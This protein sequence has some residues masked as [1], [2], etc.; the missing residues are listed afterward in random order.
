MEKQIV[1]KDIRIDA[2]TQQRPID[3]DVVSR[4]MALM[5]EGAKFPPVSIVFDGKNNWLW[6]GFHRYHVYAKLK[7]NTIIASIEKGTKRD[8]IFFSF[9]A[10]KDHGFP[11][12]Q[13][14]VKKMLL[15]K[16][17]PDEEWGAQT[18]EAIAKWVGVT[19][20]WVSMI[21]KE[22]EKPAISEKEDAR[23]SKRQVTYHSR[24]KETQRTGD[25][26]KADFQPSGD[27]GQ[28]N[29]PKILDSVGEIVPDHLV[30]IFTRVNE[31]KVLVHQL[32]RM[33]KTV[34]D[35]QA[36]ND[37]LYAYVKLNPLE[38]ETGNVKRNLRFGIPYAVC[39]H[40]R[41]E[42]KGCRVC[43]E[44]GFVSEQRYRATIEELK[45]KK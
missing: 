37:P 31:I 43:E 29:S 45:P 35:A 42:S 44:L 26:K 24:Q 3:D 12:Q 10:N 27:T 1:I 21:R 22:Y 17:L 18:D 34:K 6:D 8:A 20:P 16:I 19:R 32:N 23:Q 9:A 2:G 13:G 38:V 41:G 28:N 30:P 7:I 4:Y 15:T 5:K 14:T 36:A 25:T 11:R 39:R 40:C 33:L